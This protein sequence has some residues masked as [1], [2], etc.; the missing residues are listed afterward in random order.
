MSTT[1]AQ[2]TVAAPDTT[3]RLALACALGTPAEVTAAW[4]RWLEVT[5]FDEVGPGSYA[6]LPLMSHHL[7]ECGVDTG[8]AQGRLR[9]V[10]RRQWYQSQI[11]LQ[12]ATPVV[13]ALRGRGID[14]G[15]VGDLAVALRWYPG[16]STRPLGSVQLLVREHDLDRALD[17]L[18]PLGWHARP[19]RP[20]GQ[21]R[22]TTAGVELAGP[23]GSVRLR[24][25]AFD[26][27][28][29]AGADDRWWQ[30]ATAT[31]VDRLDLVGPDATDALLWVLAQAHHGDGPAAAWVCDA[32]RI[33]TVAGI[34][35]G[36][37]AERT[38]ERRLGPAVA[39]ALAV[40]ATV[41]PSRFGPDITGLGQVS[42]W[43]LRHLTAGA[44]TRSRWH[45][46]RLA[47]S[48]GHYLRS[49]PG[50]PTMSATHL[51]GY[52]RHKVAL[53]LGARRSR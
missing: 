32:V 2:A 44:G 16:L 3:D 25:Y 13:E 35:A 11:E 37:L 14:V 20:G 47:A 23:E 7:A 1:G 26:D 38:R 12:R 51:A 49:V 15:A 24:W 45:P 4:N 43:E 42:G 5:A 6:L 18:E 36:A 31:P 19:A 9:G 52:V 53:H 46:A 22:R 28:R 40:L 41:D 30:R 48:F 27:C 50:A 29:W 17:V 34:D 39:G 8:P 21:R 33:A 10:A